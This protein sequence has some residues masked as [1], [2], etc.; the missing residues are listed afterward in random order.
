MLEPMVS[1]SL[2]IRQFDVLSY[3]TLLQGNPDQ[4]QMEMGLR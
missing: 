4:R 2:P 1:Y 3:Y